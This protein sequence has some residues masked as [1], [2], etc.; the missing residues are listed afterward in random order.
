MNKFFK[1]ELVYIQTN[2]DLLPCSHVPLR[3]K[4]N[5]LC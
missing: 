1:V 2:H 5:K 3:L 4:E